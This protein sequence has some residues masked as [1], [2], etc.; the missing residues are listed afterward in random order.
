MG[1]RYIFGITVILLFA[2][3]MNQ[4]SNFL[5][6]VPS[7]T[8]QYSPISKPQFT[9]ATI[10]KPGPDNLSQYLLNVRFFT[11]NESLTAQ[12]NFSYINTE[13]IGLNYLYFNLWPN[14]IQNDSLKIQSVTHTTQNL[15]Y[16]L[17]GIYK[18]YLLVNL[19]QTVNP[20]NRYN[21]TINFDLTLPYTQFRFGYQLKQNGSDHDL[22]ALTNWY[23]IL[24]VYEN[25]HFVLQPYSAWGESFYSDMA[26]YNVSFTAKNNLT[27]ASGGELVSHTN[28]SILQY[29]Q[30]LFYPAREISFVISPDYQVSTLVDGNT[31]ILS[32][33]FPE[34]AFRG[35]YALNVSSFDINLFSNLYTSYPYATMSLVDMIE[36]NMEY[37]GLVELA[38]GCYNE[39]QT[40]CSLRDFEW[41]IAHEISHDWNTYLVA[42]NP[43]K[44]PWLDEGFAQ[45]SDI[46]YVENRYS[47]EEAIIATNQFKDPVNSIINQSSNLNVPIGY[48]M[49][50]FNQPGK[51]T[52]YLFSVYNKG[53]LFFNFLRS[54][55]GDT[56]FF[57]F[58]K[59]Y[60]N[61][62]TY[63]TVTQ[64][65]FFQ[66][67]YNVTSQ[68]LSWIFNTFITNSV[69]FNTLKIAN[70]IMTDSTNGTNITFDLQQV[71]NYQVEVQMPL[72]LQFDNGNIS[73]YG[74]LNGTSSKINYE[75]NVSLGK[76]QKIAI[77]PDWIYFRI[78]ET[79]LFDVSQYMMTTTTIQPTTTVPTS[80]SSSPVIS[81]STSSSSSSSSS[82][83]S[84]TY[85]SSSSSVSTSSDSAL[86]SSESS[87]TSNSSSTNVP[88]FTIKV[89][90]PS[91]LVVA[92]VRRKYV[93]NK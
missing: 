81:S 55:L 36:A 71:S 92:I 83:S 30:Y 93:K 8:N 42:N 80:S 66:V 48:G 57:T 64:E 87:R 59:E 24:A 62:F 34:D 79:L 23:P 7:K 33:Y 5:H 12:E 65:L 56:L 32:Y 51:L 77:D 76:L 10:T 72:T 17:T 2:F 27:I 63:K 41:A 68:D 20:N 67:L 35:V 25:N 31:T 29:N 28:D 60:F 9:F 46:L 70:V 58:I 1:R 39:T 69:V 19:T 38:H 18:Q 91:L 43:Y 45:Y 3:S 26:Y 78:N 13:N 49:D 85:S 88:D 82:T 84:Q 15:N 53:P 44:S 86:S 6:P 90:I 52:S 40:D 47:K 54:Y 75:A 21:L 4:S 16:S 74:W 89:L 61:E 11:E 22:Y 37:S 14:N 50:Y 73:F